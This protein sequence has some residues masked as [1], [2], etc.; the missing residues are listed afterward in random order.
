MNEIIKSLNQYGNV[1]ATRAALLSL[2]W[3]QLTKLI[4]VERHDGRFGDDLLVAMGSLPEKTRRTCSN[5]V[6]SGIVR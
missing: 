4:M 1:D 3:Q 2:T 6:K 5:L